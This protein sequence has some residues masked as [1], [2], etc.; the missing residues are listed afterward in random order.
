MTERHRI[1][2]L[3]YSA[4]R[5]ENRTE[6]ALKKKK[7]IFYRKKIGLVDTFVRRTATRNREKFYTL[8]SAIT[9][10]N[11]LQRMARFVKRILMISLLRERTSE[12]A[13]ERGTRLAGVSE[14]D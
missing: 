11:H 7:T 13:S 14:K 4:T 9:I 1:L 3:Y 12:R 5:E 6:Q 8:A 10:E 2:L